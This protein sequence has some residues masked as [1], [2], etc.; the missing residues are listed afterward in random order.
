MLR[1]AAPTCESSVI[2][3]QVNE[4]STDCF[5]RVTAVNTDISVHFQT[6]TA[7]LGWNRSGVLQ[8]LHTTVG[9]RVGALVARVAGMAAHPAPFNLVF[10]HERVQFL[11]EIG[12]AYRL[13]VGGAPTPAFPIGEPFTHALLHVL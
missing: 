4:C 8:R 6:T 2:N 7:C 1:G 13:L 11:P 5:L 3:R 9:Q 12:V 10:R